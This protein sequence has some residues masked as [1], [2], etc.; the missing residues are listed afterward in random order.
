MSISYNILRLQVQAMIDGLEREACNTIDEVANMVS[1]LR[2]HVR[3]L[4]WVKNIK[5]HIQC[6]LQAC[7]VSMKAMECALTH[8]GWDIDLAKE[9]VKVMGKYRDGLISA[10]SAV[11]TATEMEIDPNL[12]VFLR[13]F[14]PGMPMSDESA[15]V[16]RRYTDNVNRLHAARLNLE[17]RYMALQNFKKKIPAVQIRRE[18]LLMLRMNAALKRDDHVKAAKHLS[19]SAHRHTDSEQRMNELVTTCAEALAKYD[20]ALVGLVEAIHNL[21]PGG[22]NHG[23]IMKGYLRLKEQKKADVEYFA[24]AYLAV[25]LNVPMG[26]T[27]TGSSI[28]L[29]FRRL[30][31]GPALE[32]LVE[33]DVELEEGS[34]PLF[35]RCTSREDAAKQLRML[36]LT[37]MPI[38]LHHFGIVPEV[39]EI[40]Q[41]LDMF[42]LEA[43]RRTAS[44]NQN[45]KDSE[46]A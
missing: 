46:T 17:D 2:E 28:K 10:K 42:A 40:M 20:D 38:P 31:L 37:V 43:L 8:T 3:C 21:H 32:S 4:A 24:L 12:D 41:G 34:R 39:V 26:N 1:E 13:I 22:A 15:S 9:L 5:S 30:S 7:G 14:E 25:L 19:D 45:R 6:L 33:I 36:C 23:D 35:L 16:H 29:V 11:K 44:D 18:V 27:S